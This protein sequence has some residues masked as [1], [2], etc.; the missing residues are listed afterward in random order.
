MGIRILL[1]NCLLAHPAK[2]I[3]T[4][5]ALHSIAAFIFL[6]GNFACW[7]RPKLKFPPLCELTEFEFL[8]IWRL[9][10]LTR[11]SVCF[12]TAQDTQSELTFRTEHILRILAKTFRPSYN[13]AAAR[14][15]LQI[16][17]VCNLEI[18]LLLIIQDNQ[19]RRYYLLE[20]C[21]CELLFTWFVHTL[22]LHLIL[23]L[24]RCL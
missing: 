16:L 8:F 3:T 22:D 24:D 15:I 10:L 12:V 5:R 14:T 7:A 4:L 2:V 19:L 17:V 20:V 9:I 18:N 23:L 13:L 1:I 6:D 11:A 21:P